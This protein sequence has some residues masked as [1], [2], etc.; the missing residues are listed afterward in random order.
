MEKFC[1]SNNAV[2]FCDHTS[3]YKGKYKVNYAL[4]SGQTYYKKNE[5]APDLLIHIGEISGDYQSLGL[6]PKE[7]W[8]VNE[9]GEIRD[10]FC[11]LKLVFQMKES[12]FFLRYSTNSSKSDTYYVSCKNQYDVLFD[13]IPEGLPFSNIWTASVLSKKIPNGSTLHFGIL[14]SLRSWNFF[15]VDDSID[16]ACNVGGFGID[17]GMSS[18]VGASLANPNKLCFCVIGDLAF[19]YDINVLGNRHV[20]NNVR[21]LLINN[22]K[23]IEFRQYNHYAL[24]FGDAADEFIAAAGHFGNKSPELVKSFVE[25]LGYKYISASDKDEFINVYKDFVNPEIG[26]SP[27]VFE[28]FTESEKESKALEMMLNIVEK[29]TDLSLKEKARNIFGDNAVN[30]LKKVIKK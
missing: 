6:N 17:G 13:S 14:N 7:V 25:N 11:K 22:G 19:F 2:V 20:G 21:I 27:V 18:L 5:N 16:T 9:D 4:V 23:G 28:V 10:T 15:E 26:D 30:I 1:E 12:E 8:R 3:G 29:P 24:Q